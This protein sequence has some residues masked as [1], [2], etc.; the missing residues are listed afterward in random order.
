MSSVKGEML[1]QILLNTGFRKE[2]I[3]KLGIR[4]KIFDPDG[5]KTNG[6]WIRSSR[7][8]TSCEL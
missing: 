1:I 3:W 4:G 2:N 6:L 7:A 8:L 5:N